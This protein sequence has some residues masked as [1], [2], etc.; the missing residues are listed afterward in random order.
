M[1]QHDHFKFS[2]VIQSED[3]FMVSAMRGLARQCQSEINPQIAV[4]GASNAQW[5]A[6]KCKTTFYFTSRSN[7]RMFINEVSILFVTD[8]KKIR[9]DNNKT[10]PPQS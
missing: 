3:L 6:N 7:R 2:V 4:A 5:K 8:W 1:R 9:Q 10:A